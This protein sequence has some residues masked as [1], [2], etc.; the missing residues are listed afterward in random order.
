MSEVPETNDGEGSVSQYTFVVTMDGVPFRTASSLT[1]A[2]MGVLEIASDQDA[3]IQEM[4]FEHDGDGSLPRITL[5][6][7]KSIFQVWELPLIDDD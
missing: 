3:G 5:N 1:S 2:I 7:S 4:M 6:N